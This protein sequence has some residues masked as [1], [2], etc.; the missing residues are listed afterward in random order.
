MVVANDP[1]SGAII[2]SAFI[3]FPHHIKS[4]LRVNLEPVM[5]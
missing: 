3:Q 1:V 5:A 4:D 2:G